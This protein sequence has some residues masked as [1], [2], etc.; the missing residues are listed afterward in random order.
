VIAL[1][2]LIGIAA[3][4]VMGPGVN[5][6][7]GAFDGAKSD[8]SATGTADGTETAADGTV[9]GETYTVTLDASAHSNATVE[10]A[11]ITLE[12]GTAVDHLPYAKAEGMRF[13]GWRVGPEEDAAAIDNTSLDLLPNQADTTLYAHFE[14]KPTS[15]DQTVNGLPILMYHYFYDPG[16]GEVGADANHLDINMFESHLRYLSENNYYFPTWDEV[17][18]YIRGNIL[19]PQHSVVLTSDDGAENVYRL[20][21]PLVER[22]GA[23]ITLF[24]VGKDFDPS[25]MGQYDPTVVS[26]MSHSYD[27]HR[28]G[29]DDKG[30]LLTASPAEIEEDVR[31]GEQ[32]L[33]NRMVYCYPFGHCN[34]A[35]KRELTADGVQLA[36][37]IINERAYPMMDPLEVPRIRISGGNSL[38][39]FTWQVG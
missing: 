24:V 34:E 15:I 22:Y 20:A 33:G 16:S 28:P 11:T 14:P 29:N 35:A 18:E 36:M 25:L 13:T 30:R 31:L 23:R 37:A 21:I 19:L 6:T 4:M 10:P 8:L 9:A 17:N 27:M 5:T 7:R 12:K 38:E 2:A 1:V 3:F 32:V 39:T 26:F